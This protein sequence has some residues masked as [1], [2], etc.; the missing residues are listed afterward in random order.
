MGIVKLKVTMNFL[1]NLTHQFGLV[2]ILTVGAWFVL[3]GETQIGTIVAF[4]SGL[5]NINDPWGDLVSWFQNLMVTLTKYDLIIGG[6]KTI[7][8]SQLETSAPL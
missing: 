6:V 4:I 2:T 3:R 5:R 7:N 1:M 8:A